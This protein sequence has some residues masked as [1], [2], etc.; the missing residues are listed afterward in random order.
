M[1][2][3]RALKD[4][5]LV[6]GE[7]DGKRFTRRFK[8]VKK[9]SEGAFSLC[10]EAYHEGS[11]RGILKEFYPKSAAIAAERNAQGQLFF[12]EGLEAARKQFQDQLRQ[13]LE[14]YH[15]LTAAKQKQEYAELETFIPDFEIYYGCDEEKNIIGTAYIWTSTKLESFEKLCEEIHKKPAEAPEQKMVTALRA[16]ESLAKCICMLHKEGLVHRDIKPSNF[17]FIRRGSEVLT[18]TLTMFDVDSICS[19][20]DPPEELMGTEGFMEPEAAFEQPNNLTDIYAIGA[21]LFYAVAGSDET[22]SSGY[23]Y[24]EDYYP[25]LRDLINTSDLVCA[26]EANS[27]PRLR[28]ALTRILEKSLCVRGRRYSC[29]EEQLEDLETA[30]YY[31]LPS[32]IA[33]KVRNGE[34]WV[35]QDALRSL[36]REKVKNTYLAI[37]YH[38]YRHP[39]Y[40]DLPE[41][42]PVLNIMLAGFGSV[43]QKFLDACLQVG[44][45]PGKKLSVTV[46]TD[47]LEDKTLYLTDRPQLADFYDFDS[48]L[49]GGEES[50]GSVRFVQL[51]FS[52]KSS[53]K[54]VDLLQDYLCN[55][56]EE[57]QPHYIFVAL[58]DDVASQTA[59]GACRE[60][61]QVLEISC[62]ISCVCEKSHFP[63]RK[64]PGILPV[65]VGADIKKDPLS[66]EIERMAFNCHLVWEKN[67]NVDFRSVKADFLRPYNHDSCVANVLSLKYKLYGI[68]ID[69]DKAGPYKAAVLMEGRGLTSGK[70]NNEVKNELIWLEHRR[71]V[72]EKL[73]MGW[74]SIQD[75]EECA[76]GVTRDE[77]A[78]RHLCI[79]RS[80]PDQMLAAR[81]A[82]NDHALWD[83]AAESELEKLD[84]LDRMS[85][86]LHRAYVRRA[87]EIRKKN[88]LTG[89]IMRGIRMLLEGNKE[90]SRAF[91][92]W[93]VCLQ[94]IWNGDRGKGRLYQGLKND[95]L[96]A[97]AGLPESGKKALQEQIKAFEALFDPIRL[98]TEYRDW[99]Q[100]DAALIE[101]IPFILT[102]TENAYLVIPFETGG[103]TQEFHNVASATVVN[104]ARILYLFLAEKKQ[105]LE[106]LGRSLPY[107]SAYMKKKEIRAETELIAICRGNVFTGSQ[108]DAED[109]LR[110]QSGGRLRRIRMIQAEDTE[111]FVR[112]LEAYLRQR[113]RG[114]TIFALERN[115]T[116]L[117]RLLEGAGLYSRFPS[118]SFDSQQAL[119]STSS[120]AVMFRFIRKKNFI[121]AAD[122]ASVRRSAGTGSRQ[123]EFYEDY[124]NLWAR[125]S[126]NPLAW[127]LLCRTLSDHAANKDILAAFRIKEERDKIRQAQLRRYLLP[128]SCSRSA[129]RIVNYLVESGAAEKGSCVE[130]FSSG[131]C[132][133]RILDRCNYADQYD[134]LFAAVYEL[135]DPDAIR[136]WTEAKSHTV[137]A[138]FDDLRADGILIGGNRKSQFLALLRYFQNKGYIT[139]LREEA[140]DKVSFVYATRQIKELLTTEGKMLE[141]YT[142]HMAKETGQFDDVVS[143]YEIEWE[144]TDDLRNEFDC[145]LTRGFKTLFVECK[146]RAELEQN[147]YF[148]IAGL[149]RQFG[150]NTTAVMIADTREKEGGER[151]AVNEMQRK[152]GEMMNVI[153]IWK[154]EE[155]NNIGQTLLRIINGKYVVTEE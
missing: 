11:G 90:A 67:L 155:I 115:E 97:A 99:K 125:Y 95:F 40:T 66:M 2:E 6:C 120:D 94:D 60:A 82:A 7:S 139:R 45:L 107:I 73:C 32:E 58:G 54:N 14:A 84:D 124:K 29:C 20:F 9:V 15:M 142:Y 25:Q 42:A 145:I 59:A 146:A 48:S 26:S 76:D 152:R 110:R 33:K 38:L 113:S 109:M 114:K 98:S 137:R 19:V 65:F 151:A 101:N 71:W 153:T 47:D 131:A 22:K 64:Y 134:R 154:R 119:F 28:D 72:T 50:Y 3:R 74:R 141:I 106:E 102:Y 108:E 18:Q 17:G 117:S 105:D 44:Q 103:S 147:Y 81:F 130:A 88:L 127:K 57:E 123:P 143:S 62:Q 96:E 104:P 80:R 63:A 49:G 118:Y 41:E 85:V 53:K 138:A 122:M 24:R 51:S 78:K 30:L 56:G 132:Q 39:L 77:R 35:L 27:H 83:T 144:D 23:Y 37:Q 52:E 1:I 87:E 92:E 79:R 128:F 91:Q 36:D 46:L 116:G 121:T 111:V 8:I 89:S 21:T 149:A 10:Y 31:A 55:L 34:Q 135:M 68:G 126:E 16:V 129:G 69:L 100:D 133:V 75:P 86:L 150:V 4:S 13:Y 136:V 61:A 5:V 112:E 140:D 70:K 12:P 93:Y 43:G 148:K